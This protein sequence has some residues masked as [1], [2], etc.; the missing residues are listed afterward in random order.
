MNNRRYSGIYPSIFVVVVVVVFFFHLGPTNTT[1][2]LKQIIINKCR[3]FIVHY[4]PRLVIPRGL[5][6]LYR[7][8]TVS[9]NHWVQSLPGLPGVKGFIAAHFGRNPSS[10]NSHPRRACNFRTLSTE[11]DSSVDDQYSLIE[12]IHFNNSYMSF[13][14][15]SSWSWTYWWLAEHVSQQVLNKIL[16]KKLKGN[17]FFFIITFMHVIFNFL[18]QC[19]N[20]CKLNLSI[21]WC[22]SFTAA[23]STWG[24]CWRLF[25]CI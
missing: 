14:T 20:T 3:W 18:L 25:Y 6:A 12:M 23:A 5:S 16:D 9:S 24:A 11:L 10:S 13:C 15:H 21:M 17:I 8:H 1:Q 19:E 4:T 2:T 22:A 7:A